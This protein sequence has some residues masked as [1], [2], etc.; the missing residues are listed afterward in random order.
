MLEEGTQEDCTRLAFEVAESDF[1][2]A[3]RR[4]GASSLVCRESSDPLPGIGKA[5]SFTDCKGT[6]IELFAG[7]PD[8]LP[9]STADP[10]VAVEERARRGI[11]RI[12]VP[13]GPF[14]PDLEG[15]LMRF[16]ETVIRPFAGL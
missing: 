4:L 12:V 16:G 14:V 3:T 9:G 7:C 2:E 11:G 5:V 8:L 1:G 10:R 15:S 13:V 6:V